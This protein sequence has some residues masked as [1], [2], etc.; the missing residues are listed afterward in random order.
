MRV[1]H[2]SEIL[3]GGPS[4]YLNQLL[5]LQVKRYDEVALVC[6][7]NQVSLIE[8]SEKLKIFGV[9]YSSRSYLDLIKLLLGYVKATNT[10]APDVVHIHSTFA[11]LLARIVPIREKTKLVYCSHGWSFSM[12]V[13]KFK[14]SVYKAV[15]RLLASRCHSIINISKNELNSAIDAMLPRSKLKLVYNGIEE[16]EWQALPDELQPAR[17]LFVGRYDRQ[18]GLDLL[19][20]AMNA[21]ELQGYELKTIGGFAVDRDEGLRFPKHVHDLGWRSAAQ[22]RE[23]M[24]RSHVVV[25]PSRWEGFGLVAVEAMRAGRPVVATRVGGL[26]EVVSHNKTGLLVSPNS[27]AELVKA[28][29]CLRSY[30]ISEMGRNGRIR[31]EN[32]FRSAD[33]EK[34]IDE[35]YNAIT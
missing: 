1:L 11:G 17:L 13:S 18:K 7:Q 31:F 9:K 12:D 2:F 26:C 22:V 5:P 29:V 25:M 24:E 3:H 27:S 35:I 15:E 20:E 30:N 33:M 32:L 21:N 16:T 10:F 14:K 28:L 34:K 8:N 4:T 6:P 23:E 19:L